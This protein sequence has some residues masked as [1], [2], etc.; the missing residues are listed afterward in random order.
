[1]LI[2]AAQR[3]WAQGAQGNGASGA[4]KTVLI[5]PKVTEAEV[6]QQLKFT[7]VGLDAEGKA[8]DQ[9]PMMWFAAPVD[10]AAAEMPG[11]VTFYAPGEVKVG[12]LVGGKVDFATVRVR[13]ARVK[14]I[15][16]AP[17]A[18]SLAVGGATKL[19]VT[20]RTADGSP[21]EDVTI[22]WFSETP[23]VAAV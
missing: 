4:V 5:S 2:A 22:Q 12:A 13:P 15:D 8:T 11:V 3:A 18:S 1:V 14:R 10:L 7:A 23:S 9:K 16:A 20:A 6:G 19:N 17:A 21:R